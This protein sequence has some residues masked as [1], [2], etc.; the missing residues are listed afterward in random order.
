MARN[1]RLIVW[2]ETTTLNS[3]STHWRRSTSRQRT[4]PC[5]ARDRPILHH[6][7]QGGA[8]LHRQPR[9]LT[10]RPAGD[11]PGRTA[12]VELHHPVPDDLKPHA[13]DL[14]RLRPRRPV[15]NRRQSQEPARLAAVLR[16]PRLAAKLGGVKILSKRDRHRKLLRSQHRIKSKP[17]RESPPSQDQKELVLQWRLIL[18]QCKTSFARKTPLRLR[19]RPQTSSRYSIKACLLKATDHDARGSGSE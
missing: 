17:I 19:R 10:G 2:T 15:V 13:G 1:S 6:A 14:R 12:G 11:Q 18:A 5:T 3:S 16:F 7:S 9:R 4:T 8:M